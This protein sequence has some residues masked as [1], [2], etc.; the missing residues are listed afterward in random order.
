VCA[1]I[2]PPPSHQHVDLHTQTI[3]YIYVIVQQIISYTR[4]NHISHNDPT[5][6]THSRTTDNPHAWRLYTPNIILANK[7]SRLLGCTP[8]TTCE[9]HIDLHSLMSGTH[10][11]SHAR[12][13]SSKLLS[14]HQLSSTH[15]INHHSIQSDYSP[16][17]IVPSTHSYPTLPSAQLH[18]ITSVFVSQ[19]AHVPSKSAL[20][21][22]ILVPARH[23]PSS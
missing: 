11:S 9:H 12:T 20:L 19:P 5:W 23:N 6:L 8:T 1:L 3:T 13:Q 22:P 4:H 21:Q 18:S 10:Q 2:D 15:T 14:T 17:L 16:L 7:S